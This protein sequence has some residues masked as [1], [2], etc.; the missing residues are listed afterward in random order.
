V[1]LFTSLALAAAGCAQVDV[2][3]PGVDADRNDGDVD[4]DEVHDGD[5]DG[6]DGAIAPAQLVVVT[7]NTHSFQEGLDSLEKLTWIGE[8][9]AALEADLIGLNEVMSGTFWAY[10]FEGEEHDG[11]AL[12]LESL[13]AASGSSYNLARCAF[14]HW[15]DGEEMSNVVLSRYPL[16]ERECRPL[17]TTD[18]WPAPGEQ[19]NVLQ[20]R[21]DVPGFGRVNFFVTHTWAYGSADTEVQIDEVRTFMVERFRGDEALDLLVGDLNV[22]P[23]SPEYEIWLDSEPFELIDTYGETNPGGFLDS[24]LVSRSSRIDYIL[25]GGGFDVVE[26]PA[27]YRSA[28]V[29]DG[30]EYLGATLPVVSDHKGVVTIFDLSN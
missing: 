9:L 28:I 7:L 8:G 4:A 12:I 25:A 26:P 20:V 22:T 10:H 29:F 1:T 14:G 23:G 2:G 16:L 15:D 17:T 30:S 21:V 13:E 5:M 18:S 27:T 19:R 6:D 24:T 11:A 3:N